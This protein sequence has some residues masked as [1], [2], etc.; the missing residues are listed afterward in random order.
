MDEAVVHLGSDHLDERWI[1]LPLHLVNV[2]DALHL[3]DDCLVVRGDDL[4]TVAPEDLVTV[5]LLGIVRGSH[6]DATLAAQLTDRIGNHRGR[7]Q[8]IVE[9]D[10]DA[11]CRK[12]V[13]R[14][15][16]EEGAV[17][18]PI[19]ADSYGDLFASEALQ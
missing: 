4:S 10:L 18:A 6:H 7:A 3:I 16:S 1:A 17:V 15:L 9:V 8:R 12:H 2:C 14:R 13:G 5:V 11:V 19:V